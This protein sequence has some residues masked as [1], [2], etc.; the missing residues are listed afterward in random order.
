M[1]CAR[2]KF[3][4][5]DAEHG[6]ARTGRTDNVIAIAE[7]ADGMKC[8]ALRFLPVTGV[9]RGLSAA[10]LSFGVMDS[11]AEGFEDFY[12]A[13]GGF[14]V[15]LVNETGNEQANLHVRCEGG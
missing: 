2:K 4:V 12:D 11:V 7:L 1:G 14:G 6:T 3:G 5:K 8:W 10:G 15:E 9:E 13:E